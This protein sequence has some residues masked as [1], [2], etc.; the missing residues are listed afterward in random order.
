MT[1]NLPQPKQVTSSPVSRLQWNA[2]TVF[3]FGLN[4]AFEINHSLDNF[5]RL[6]G[7]T[8]TDLKQQPL[9]QF[10]GKLPSTVLDEIHHALRRE[11]PWRGILPF[12]CADG[13]LHWFD[14]IV[15]GVFRNGQVTGSQWLMHQASDIHA[16]RAEKVYTRQLPSVN[17][18]YM[19]TATGLSV[20]AISIWLIS[21]WTLLPLL[22]MA[23]LWV[24]SLARQRRFHLTL[25]DMDGA[26]AHW[27]Q[28][29][30]GDNSALG[31]AIYEIALRDASILALTTR[32]E[33]GTSVLSDAISSTRDNAERTQQTTARTVDSVEQ[34][35]ASMEQMASA[36]DDI[37]RSAAESS[38]LSRTTGD[39]MRNVTRFISDNT[40]QL[41]Q[42]AN[43]VRGTAQ[44]THE[45][46]DST[47]S[48][49][50]VSQQIYAIAEQTNLLAL[51]AA[52]EAARAG[53]HGR[54]FSVVA[55]EVRNLSERTQ[56]AVDDIEKTIGGMTQIMQRWQRHMEAQRDLAIQCSEQAEN[57]RTQLSTLQDSVLN[58]NDRMGE[59]AVAAEEHSSVVRNVQQ[60]I[61]QVSVAARETVTL[62]EAT[63][64]EVT[65]IN[66]RLR[67]F[68]S[69]VEAFEED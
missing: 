55:D 8:P 2:N 62:A 52:I 41:I 56:H 58:I 37:A 9:N 60:N 33:D 35:S 31:Q 17:S 65:T 36:V 64:S 29:I 42:L 34:M 20:A 53:E 57:S 22:V 63:T 68:R 61:E 51:N 28:R 27:Q 50:T 3:V 4:N 32:L 48:V 6:M 44:S 38:S 7:T 23:A 25:T 26:H 39:T 67:E 40:E 46:V 11:V 24:F 19:Y 54:G 30:F 5:A 18:T 1:R 49:K 16:A 10:L 66:R 45:L 59:I 43:D 69:L 12:H 15:R 47:E 21:L 14:V 13:R